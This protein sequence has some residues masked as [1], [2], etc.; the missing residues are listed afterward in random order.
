MSHP[1]RAPS[2]HGSVESRLAANTTNQ[3]VGATA[4]GVAAAPGLPFAAGWPAPPPG[5][6]GVGVAL[7]APAGEVGVAGLPPVCDEQAAISSAGASS[8][9]ARKRMAPLHP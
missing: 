8:A 1:W 9:A 7:A 3:F 4:C 5:A 2:W 6:V